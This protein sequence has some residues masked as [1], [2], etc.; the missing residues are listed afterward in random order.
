MILSE[1]RLQTSTPPERVIV[2]GIE[3]SPGSEV[4]ITPQLTDA[5]SQCS[6]T[7]VY[8]PGPPAPLPAR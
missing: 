2:N 7:T 5:E 4:T 1:T 3:E 8:L 6:H